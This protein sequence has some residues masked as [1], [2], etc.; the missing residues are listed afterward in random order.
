VTRL[1]ADSRAE[2]LLA[3]GRLDPIPHPEGNPAL[4][5]DSDV[6]WGRAWW[7]FILHA[8]HTHNHREAWEQFSRE[9]VSGIPD[10]CTCGHSGY[11]GH[12]M[13]QSPPTCLTRG[14]YCG[15]DE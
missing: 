13:R 12:D 5:Y 15:G 7:G 9:T 8:S 10:L 4:S 11:D 2:R 6:K 14:C 3:P 1:Y